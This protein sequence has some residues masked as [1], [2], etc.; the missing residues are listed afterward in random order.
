MSVWDTKG[1]TK[2]RNYILL[3]HT[4]PNVSYTV[5]SVKFRGGYAVV[6]KDSKTYHMLKKIPVLR[7]AQEFPLTLLRK[8]PFITRTSDIQTIF[9]RDILVKFLEE[10]K[11]LNAVVAVEKHLSEDIKC[12][13]TTKAGELCEFP[14]SEVSPSGFCHK[15]ILQDPELSRLGIEVP[16]FMTK[17]ERTEMRQTVINKLSRI[18][19]KELFKHKAQANG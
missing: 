7:S 2:D 6:E 12:K 15:H 8:L 14:A 16:Q 13:N 18:S 3:K 5:G 10:E 9:G 11:K 1:S 17:V 4:L 19:K